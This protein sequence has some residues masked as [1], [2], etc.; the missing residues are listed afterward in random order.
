[1]LQ[2]F[3]FGNF[4]NLEPH[5]YEEH[6]YTQQHICGEIDGP[7]DFLT[8]RCWSFYYA[9]MSNVLYANSNKL[10]VSLSVFF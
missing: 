7:T 9:T 5:M 8:R 3:A 4:Y 6:V 1:M 2:C 10:L